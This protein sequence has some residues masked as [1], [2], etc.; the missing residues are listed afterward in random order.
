V[1]QFR[2]VAAQAALFILEGE[3]PTGKLFT[4]LL[5]EYA[6]RMDGD[7]SYFPVKGAPPGL[8]L[9]MMK[10]A[11]DT[12]KLQITRERVDLFQQEKE[13]SE[14]ALHSFFHFATEVF[15]DYVT[16][17]DARVGR[18]AALVSRVAAVEN[19]AKTLAQHFCQEKWLAG[20]IN[21]PGDFELHTHKRF[22]L[23]TLFDINSWI[24]FKTGI[25]AGSE[26]GPSTLPNVIIVEQDFN[27][28]IEEGEPKHISR[29][30]IT[31]FFQLAPRELRLVLDRYF[32]EP[33]A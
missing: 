28:L 20:P 10:S 24:R 5:Q 4:H 8:P 32:P 2:T 6:K 31:A 22:R 30:E 33:T 16:E 26:G 7:P 29:E 23:E 1:S 12:L 18:V 21:R 25:L 13:I 14:T 9:L 27:S 11:D 15:L 17:T 19:P 3:A